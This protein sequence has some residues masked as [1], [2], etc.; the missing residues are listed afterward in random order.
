VREFLTE[1][2]ILTIPT[3]WGDRI[4]ALVALALFGDLLR[5]FVRF[6]VMPVVAAILAGTAIL[7]FVPAAAVLRRRRACYPK[8]SPL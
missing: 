7:V 5:H 2:R 4:A 8:R 1:F 6:G 3:T